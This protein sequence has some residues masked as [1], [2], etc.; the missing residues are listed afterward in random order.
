MYAV[1]EGTAW[2]TIAVRGIHTQNFQSVCWFTTPKIDLGS[3]KKRHRK[4][5]KQ[6]NYLFENKKVLVEEQQ[7]NNM[8]F[9]SPVDKIGKKNKPSKTKEFCYH[10]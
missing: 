4:F 1:Y 7:K 2:E 10:G 3:G 8:L 9:Q 6:T 5:L